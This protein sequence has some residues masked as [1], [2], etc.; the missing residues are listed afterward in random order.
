MLNE[1]KRGCDLVL[2]IQK[3][4]VSADKQATY[5]SSYRNMVGSVANN[6]LMEGMVQKQP[7]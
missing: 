3:D 2:V 6:Q 5:T 1:S 4:R 7:M